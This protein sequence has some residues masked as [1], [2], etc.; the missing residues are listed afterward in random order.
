MTV[1]NFC[2]GPAMLPPAVMEKAQAEFINWQG[3]GVSVMEISHRSK[4]FLKL[5]EEC[6]ASLRRLMNIS[7]EFEVLFMHGGGRGHFSAVPLNLHLD[8]APG[9]YVENGIWSV[10]ATKEG[11]KF[12]QVESV[13]IR[14][15]KDG[16]FDILPVS[17]WSLPQNASFIHYCPNE[18]IDGIEIFEVPKHPTAPIVADM[19]SM[20]LSREINVD[21][22]DLIYAGAQKKY[23]SF[24]FKYRNYSQDV[25]RKRR[26][27][28]ACNFRLCHRSKAK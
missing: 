12:T 16:Q 4:P 24:W 23:W 18:T 22:F 27:A 21:D 2:A 15:D 6:E 10:G 9:V 13:D 1:Y 26:P 25:I 5:A 7:D 8:S 20:I 17:E 28:K 14:T 3:L 11:A 19:S